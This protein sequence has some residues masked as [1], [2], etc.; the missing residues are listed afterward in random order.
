LGGAVVNA[1]VTLNNQYPIQVVAKLSQDPRI[2]LT[3]LDLGQRVEIRE[4]PSAAE[5]RDPRQWSAL[6]K[7]A[8]VL[9]GLCPADTRL[10]LRRW[11]DRLGGG[12]EI[13]IFSAVP[14]GS[15]LGTS[16]ILGAAMLACLARVVGEPVTAETLIARTSALEQ[17]MTTA[18]GWQ[19]QVGGATPGVKLIRTRPGPVQTPMLHRTV[20]DLSPGGELRSRLLLYYT[21]YQRMAKNIL[22]N[23]V[24]RYLDRDP[25]AIAIIH[26]L[27][28]GAECMKDDLAGGDID[29]FG[30]GV[31]LY[32][33]LKKQLDPGSTNARIEGLLQPVNRY[34]TGK[35]LAGAGGGGFIF[36]VA[37]DAA[38]AAKAKKLLEQ[39]PPNK[40]A[41]FFDF[42]VDNRGLVVT[43]L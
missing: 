9:G 10:P 30:R 7:A 28:E 17:F 33:Y 13:T 19:D 34:L 43:V 14:K 23:V 8:L 37:K 27:K 22:Q 42:D 4:T 20:F 29:A 21:G 40:M 16:S 3:S 35:T 15:G 24:G 11:L 25:E 18:G 39:R 26:R 38:A 5:Y 31:E 12:L 1:A 2:T 32:W 41:R 6:A 36:M